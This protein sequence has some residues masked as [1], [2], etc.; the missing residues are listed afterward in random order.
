L[1]RS[2]ARAW[3]ATRTFSSTESVGKM[4]VSWKERPIPAR[5]RR[6]A[7]QPVMS[8]P[9]KAIRPSDAR[10]CPE[11]RLKSVVFPAPLGPMMLLSARGGTSRLTWSTAT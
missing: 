1:K 11:R 5:V 8:R 4:L 3:S 10:Y 9:L 2:P 6:A 7:L